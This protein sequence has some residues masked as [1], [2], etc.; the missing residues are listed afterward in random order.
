[1]NGVCKVSME[2]KNIQSITIGK[3]HWKRLLKYFIYAI[4][5]LGIVKITQKVGQC[6]CESAPKITQKW[7]QKSLK[8]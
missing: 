7:S 5:C 3:I 2:D 6:G 1:M 4:I 8:C